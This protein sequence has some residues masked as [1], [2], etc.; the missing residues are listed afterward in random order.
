V[1]RLVV[2]TNIIVSSFL[3]SG[4]P[5]QVLNRIRDGQDQLCLSV[6]ILREYL[7]VLARAGV[8]RELLEV[9]LS[10][11]E[12]PERIIPVVPSRRVT[13][14]RD[15]PADNMFL[16]CALEAQA[17]YIISGDQHLKRL[18]TFEGIRIL[19]PKAY[20]TRMGTAIT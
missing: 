4:P 1:S 7:E 2:D 16:E 11:F 5:R 9:L 8:A 20:L 12:D 6:P 19:S 3:T 18:G 14:I 13:L 17:N 10:L 15:D